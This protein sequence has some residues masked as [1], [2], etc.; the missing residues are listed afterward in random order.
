[1]RITNVAKLI[2][3]GM[4]AA[5][6][7][8]ACTTSAYPDGKAILDEV[9]DVFIPMDI[10]KSIHTAELIYE[11]TSPGEPDSK[12]IVRYQAPNRYRFDWISAKTAMI[13]CVDGKKGW[14]YDQEGGIAD[15]TQADLDALFSEIAFYPF[16]RVFLDNI[17]KAKVVGEEVF[18]GEACWVIEVRC[19]GADKPD[20]YWIGKESKM[21]R[22][23]QSDVDGVTQTTQYFDFEYY[24]GICLANIFFDI[25]K[26]KVTRNK[27]VSVKINSDVDTSLFEKLKKLD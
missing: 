18:H 11:V 23:T 2:L 21:L 27:L 12:M 24:N 19:Q 25:T 7:C 16:S 17:E 6:L 22:Q 13:L 3:G 10:V 15:M 14:S 26:D 8:V 20:R 1:M 4:T 9:E 5:W